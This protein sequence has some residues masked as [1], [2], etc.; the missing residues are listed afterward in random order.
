MVYF[1]PYSAIFCTFLEDIVQAKNS[2]MPNLPLVAK[3]KSQVS[4]KHQNWRLLD[5]LAN[6]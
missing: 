1:S 2:E 6:F 4:K 3:E 5:L